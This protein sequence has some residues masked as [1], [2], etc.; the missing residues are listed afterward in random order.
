MD[1]VINYYN[2]QKQRIFVEDFSTAS[3]T[4]QAI[5]EAGNYGCSDMERG[6][7]DIWL[8][9]RKVARVSYNGRVWTMDSELIAEAS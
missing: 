6:C 7:G 4:F 3:K 8:G 5:R 2:C 9:N 1:L